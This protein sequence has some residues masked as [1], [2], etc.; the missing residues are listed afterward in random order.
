LSHVNAA[1]RAEPNTAIYQADAG[2][3]LMALGRNE[4]ALIPL[5]RATVL[6]PSH[7]VA[8]YNMGEAHQ[9]LGQKE[10]AVEAFK[11]AISLDRSLAWKKLRSAFGRWFGFGRR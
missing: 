2:V 10:A 4:E 6:D 9:F 8:H 7:A 11:T 1:I 3:I 5:K